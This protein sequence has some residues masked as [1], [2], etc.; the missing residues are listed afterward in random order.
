MKFAP[1]G[2]WNRW[3]GLIALL[4]VGIVIALALGRRGEGPAAGESGSESPAVE[5]APKAAPDQATL[6]DRLDSILVEQE[7][8][9]K[10][11]SEAVE[12]PD[13]AEHLEA[14]ETDLEPGEAAARLSAL[15][16]LYQMKKGDFKAAAGY[17]EILIERYPTWEGVLGTYRELVTCY[18]MLGEQQELRALYRRMLEKFPE[19]SDEYRAA[20]EVLGK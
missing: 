7:K 8:R 16:N 18:E 20:R 1:Q 4:A 11:S 13:I 14:L 9:Q 3:N 10:G 12:E 15:G 19:D 2:A 5:T 6:S 17:Y